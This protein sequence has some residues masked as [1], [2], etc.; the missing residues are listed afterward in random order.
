ML[1]ANGRLIRLGDRVII[2]RGIYGI[3]VF[4]IDTDE[5]SPEFSKN[6]WAYLG[7]GIG[8][9]TDAHGLFHY[10]ESD[11]DLEV[12]SVTSNSDTTE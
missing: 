6:D 1:D 3:I 5:F 10:E 9:Q 2:G 4:S 11:E 12:I 8:I 7:R